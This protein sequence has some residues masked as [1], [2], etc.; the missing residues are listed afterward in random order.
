VDDAPDKTFAIVNMKEI[1]FMSCIWSANLI[2][3]WD[4]ANDTT[5]EPSALDV[6]TNIDY[7]ED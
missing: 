7:Y 5:V 6:H 2:E 3:I 1:D 4:E